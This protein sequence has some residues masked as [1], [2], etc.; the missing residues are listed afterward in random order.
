MSITVDQVRENVYPF[1]PFLDLIAQRTK[2]TADDILATELRRALANDDA[3]AGIVYCVNWV[4][5]KVSSGEFTPE[6]AAAIQQAIAS[7][8]Q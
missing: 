6:D 3:M 7:L 4:L 2:T 5:S 8:P 1:L